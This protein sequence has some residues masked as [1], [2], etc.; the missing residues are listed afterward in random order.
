MGWGGGGGQGAFMCYVDGEVQMKPN[1]YTS[2]K[3][4]VVCT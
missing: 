1:C 2:R 4:Q 3:L